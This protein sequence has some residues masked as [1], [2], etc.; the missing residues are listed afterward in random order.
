MVRL[1]WPT[2]VFRVRPVKT[3]VPVVF[4]GGKKTPKT[5]GVRTVRGRSLTYGSI[6]PNT[7]DTG[8]TRVVK[9]VPLEVGG[10]GGLES[11]EVGSLV[12]LGVRGR[13]VG[14]R[15]PVTRLCGLPR[16]PRPRLVGTRGPFLETER[17][18]LFRQP[19]CRL[20]GFP[21]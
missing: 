15:L 2:Q 19:E 1:L 20:F 18:S 12:A 3:S 6:T 13:R 16:P 7:I 10:V 4:E 14:A 21:T 17:S 11:L 8:S 9:E 5:F